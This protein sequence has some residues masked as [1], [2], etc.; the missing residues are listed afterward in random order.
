MGNIRVGVVG[1]G[2]LGM[3]HARIYNEIMG[4]ELV[5]VADI[6]KERAGMIGDRFCVPA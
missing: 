1:V 4:A 2:H 6:D 5:G 3:H